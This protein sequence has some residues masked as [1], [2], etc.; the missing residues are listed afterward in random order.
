MFD[1]SGVYT[2]PV[3]TVLGLISSAYTFPLVS[4]VVA[5]SCFT[6]SLYP[7]A[8]ID[9]PVTGCVA[10]TLMGFAFNSV[11]KPTPPTHKIPAEVNATEVG[12]VPTAIVAVTVPV[13]RL[14]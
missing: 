9:F 1:A 4:T 13:V 12:C 5:T 10:I 14:T 7:R 6:E 8:I 11:R 3:W 2:P